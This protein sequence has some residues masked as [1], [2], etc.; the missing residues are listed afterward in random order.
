MQEVDLMFLCRERCIR[1]R[2]CNLAF[3][4]YF[5]LPL[6]V[7]SHYEH[8]IWCIISGNMTYANV[9]WTYSKVLRVINCSINRHNHFE[10]LS[11]AQVNIIDKRLFIKG[12]WICHG[13]EERHLLLLY[14]ILP[15]YKCIICFFRAEDQ[16]IFAQ[17]PDP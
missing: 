5:L 13:F 8:S 6:F 1:Y 3:Y 17:P 16:G 11:S 2:N 14:N 4:L 12:I 15:K 10:L 9:C 7:E